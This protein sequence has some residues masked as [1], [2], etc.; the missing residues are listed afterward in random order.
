[1]EANHTVMKQVRGQLITFGPLRLMIVLPFPGAYGHMC[2]EILASLQYARRRNLAVF[3]LRPMHQLKAI[4]NASY[5]RVWTPDVSTVPHT[6]LTNYLFLLVWRFLEWRQHRGAAA[7]PA[8]SDGKSREGLGM[9]WRGLRKESANKGKNGRDEELLMFPFGSQAR[10]LIADAPLDIRL[11]R[12]AERAVLRTLRKRGLREK[13][14]FVTLHVR[15]R[16]SKKERYRNASIDNYVDAVQFLVERGYTVVRIGEPGEPIFEHPGVIDL[17]QTP[18]RRDEEI[19][20]LRHSVFFLG[21]DSGPHHAAYLLGCPSLCV[22]ICNILL[23]YPIRRRDLYI[24]KHVLDRTT[25]R[26]LS[27]AERMT[28]EFLQN[29]YDFDRYE[30]IENTSAEILAATEE[31]LGVRA[32]GVATTP[33]QERYRVLA[34]SAAKE[35]LGRKTWLRSTIGRRDLFLGKGRIGHAFAEAHLGESISVST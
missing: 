21:C 11:P 4:V 13:G 28:V 34:H 31:M 3:F 9:S 6:R 17:S 33:A 1:M 5:Y 20:F 7:A 16:A 32:G 29:Q 14:P 15:G 35:M 30:Y 25:G 8:A 27:L 12:R 22:N 19:W 10:R 2:L 18:G 26:R 23:L 24:P